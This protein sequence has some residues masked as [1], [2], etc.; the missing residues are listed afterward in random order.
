[1]KY[2]KPPKKP[3]AQ[4][5]K[6]MNDKMGSIASQLG[7]IPGRNGLNSNYPKKGKA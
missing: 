5:K 4:A 7:G 2:G 6:K 1:M 3:T